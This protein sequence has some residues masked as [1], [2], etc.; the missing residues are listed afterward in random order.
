MDAFIDREFQQLHPAPHSPR[1]KDL[2]GIMVAISLALHVISSV[3]LLSPH[4]NQMHNPPVSYL[5]LKNM[6]FQEEITSSPPKV[7]QTDH[8]AE[9]LK[10]VLPPLIDSLTPASTPL[11]ETGKLQKDVQNSLANAEKNPESLQQSS[12]GL[13]LSN[14]YFSSIAEG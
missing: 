6:Q 4:N 8:T 14:G 5:D 7:Q 3:V 1:P 2:F 9:T 13:G 11:P 10:E 12:L